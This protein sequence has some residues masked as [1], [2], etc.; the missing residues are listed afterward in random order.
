MFH[1]D[2]KEKPGRK[3]ALQKLMSMMGKQTSSKLAGLKKPGMA[4]AEGSPAEE[5]AES[6]ADEAAEGGGFCAHC[7]KPR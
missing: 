7:G 2:E 5:A 3:A 6:P 1:I 4:P